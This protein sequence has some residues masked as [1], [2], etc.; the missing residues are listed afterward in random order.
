[1]IWISES[2]NPYAVRGCQVEIAPI[3]DMTEAED[4]EQI[5]DRSINDMQETKASLKPKHIK[6]NLILS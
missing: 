2:Q 4:P 5:L 6:E 3:R 1:M